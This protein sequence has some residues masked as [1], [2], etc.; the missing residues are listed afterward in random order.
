M[1]K[2]DTQVLE[3]LDIGNKRCCRYCEEYFE[4]CEGRIDDMEGD[5]VCTKCM[6]E[7]NMDVCS[8]CGRIEDF[9]EDD[10]LCE[11]CSPDLYWKDEDFEDSFD[12]DWD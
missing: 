1:F 8:N 2:E 12:P 10:G 4:T 3:D 11:I 5:F 6:T 9:F 7:K